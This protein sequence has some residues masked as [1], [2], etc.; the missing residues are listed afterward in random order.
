MVIALIGRKNNYVFRLLTG[1]SLLTPGFTP[2]IDHQSKDFDFDP[3][4]LKLFS[5]GNILTVCLNVY[6]IYHK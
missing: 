4:S 1:Q 5:F 2:S 3:E 6:S